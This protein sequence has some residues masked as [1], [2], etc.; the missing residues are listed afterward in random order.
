MGQ[1]I[2][3][4]EDEYN[5]FKN[6]TVLGKD[7]YKMINELRD[8]MYPDIDIWIDTGSNH[9]VNEVFFEKVK[10]DFKKGY[11]WKGKRFFEK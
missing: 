9:M 8:M 3:I 10:E 6:Y 4:D 2:F 1:M 7:Y 5:E 11:R